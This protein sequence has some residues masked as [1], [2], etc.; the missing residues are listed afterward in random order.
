[1]AMSIWQK[2]DEK[3]D[4]VTQFTLQDISDAVLQKDIS[5]V[6][7]D[8]ESLILIYHIQ[9]NVNNFQKRY[10][11]GFRLQL[12]GKSQK[13]E[14]WFDGYDGLNRINFFQVHHLYKVN[15]R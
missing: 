6:A 7:R 5:K 9:I 10:F 8:I 4:S 3:E 1:M 14:G 15:N 12:F 2:Y 11:F 13:L